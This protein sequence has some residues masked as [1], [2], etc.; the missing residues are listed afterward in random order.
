MPPPGARGLALVLALSGVG[1]Y[2]WLYALG[3]ASTSGFSAALLNSVS[4]LI[5]MLLVVLFG[6]EHMSPL[7]GR[8][9]AR[10]LGRSRTLRL[11]GPGAGLRQH[12]GEPHVPRS[13]HFVGRL[14]RGVRPRRPVPL[15]S[16]R[17]ARGLLRRDRPGS[18]VRPARHAPAGLR[19]RESVGVGDRRPFGRP[20]PRRRLP[21][22]ARGRAHARRRAGDEL[23]LPRARSRRYRIGDLHGRALQRA[24]GPVGGRRALRPRAHAH[25]TRRSPR[26]R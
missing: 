13:G 12:G 6:W 5:A 4:P 23:R 20:S 14:Q 7:A 10:R 22:L 21:P 11:L 24:E 1:V 3:L 19:A 16:R 2:Q 9:L 18:R 8:G 26:A 25:R 17:A 15:A